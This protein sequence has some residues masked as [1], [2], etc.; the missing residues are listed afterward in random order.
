[1]GLKLWNDG[2]VP[3]QEEPF[4]PIH[5]K[6]RRTL[7]KSQLTQGDILLG[8]GK[9]KK[10]KKLSENYKSIKQAD[11]VADVPSPMTQNKTTHKQHRGCYKRA[12]TTHLAPAK[13]CL[14]IIS[15]Q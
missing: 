3:T 12:L 10:K 11:N 13:L 4:T 7:V 8:G 14:T 9:K 15:S 5:T 2:T 6:D 1:M